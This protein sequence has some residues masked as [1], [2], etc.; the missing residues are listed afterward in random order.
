[1]LSECRRDARRTIGVRAR[2]RPRERI[3][4]RPRARS[5]NLFS[6]WLLGLSLCVFVWRFD[7]F[8][9]ADLI[10]GQFGSRARSSALLA[11][12]LTR[13]LT[14]QVVCGTVAGEQETKLFFWIE[15]V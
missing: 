15:I 1:M 10:G 2:E 13:A 8:W 5:R 12:S 9:L 11:R 6:L 3:T 7:S 4:S 14:R